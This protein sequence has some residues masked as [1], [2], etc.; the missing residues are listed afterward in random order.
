MDLEAII[1]EAN[2]YYLDKGLAVIYKKPTPIGI[3]KVDYKNNGKITEAYFKE[4][5]T[6]D[7]NGI[8]N[9]YYVEFDAKET[10]NRTSFPLSNIHEHQLEHMKKIINQQGI[11]FLLIAINDEYYCLS[12][13]NIFDY[14]ENNERKS[15]DYNYIKNKGFKVNY[16]YLKGLDYINFLDKEIYEKNKN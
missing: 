10:K 12:G 16:N 6:L 4:P 13:E 1:S 5:S 9:G 3:V 8:Y 2:K 14:I 15:I 7:Y 11:C